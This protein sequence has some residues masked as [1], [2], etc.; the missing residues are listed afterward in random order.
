MCVPSSHLLSPLQDPP[1]A[2][3]RFEFVSPFIEHLMPRPAILYIE[4][5]YSESSALLQIRQ[6]RPVC[7]QKGGGR[8]DSLP[9]IPNSPILLLGAAVTSKLRDKG[10]QLSL[11]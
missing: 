4:L 1:S 9:V 2:R 10:I 11:L 6:R 3:V 5:S 8:K 7:R